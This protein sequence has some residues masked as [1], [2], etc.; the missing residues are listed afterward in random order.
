MSEE[1]MRILNL[2]EQGKIDA[3]QAAALLDALGR[4]PA[5]PATPSAERPPRAAP[6][7]LRVVVEGGAHDRVNVRVPFDLIR[8]GVR[9]A[10]FLPPGVTDKINAALRDNGLALDVSKLRPEGLEE[11]VA[12]L[13]ELTV[14]VDGDGERVRI[15][16]E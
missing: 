14:D 2:L 15:F 9:L 12:H 6:R 10:A 1:R 11:L 16:C 8:A 13:G 7:W 4:A 5:P 3:A